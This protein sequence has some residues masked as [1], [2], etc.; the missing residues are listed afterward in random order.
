MLLNQQTSVTTTPSKRLFEESSSTLTARSTRKL[1]NEIIDKTLKIDAI[2]AILIENREMTME[3]ILSWKP[4]AGKAYPSEA[5]CELKS[6]RTNIEKVKKSIADDVE[7]DEN[8][9]LVKDNVAILNKMAS[10]VKSGKMNNIIY[11]MATY[12]ELAN[13]TALVA[14]RNE[15]GSTITDVSVLLFSMF[16]LV[17]KFTLQP[18]FVHLKIFFLAKTRLVIHVMLVTVLHPEFIQPSTEIGILSHLTIP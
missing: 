8:G 16:L 2:E 18:V 5:Y 9:V 6:L 15:F 11:D 13:N 14:I 10:D 17:S 12:K 4:N 3:E 7:V 1:T